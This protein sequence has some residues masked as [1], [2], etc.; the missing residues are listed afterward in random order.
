MFG[1]IVWKFYL[2]PNTYGEKD[3]LNYTFFFGRL[4]ICRVGIIFFVT[5][6]GRMNTGFGGHTCMKPYQYLPHR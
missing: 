1:L 5:G 6:F 4:M 3:K 2:L